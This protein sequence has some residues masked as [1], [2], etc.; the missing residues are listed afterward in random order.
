MVDSAFGSSTLQFGFAA[1]CRRQ[2][3]LEAQAIQSD[4][5]AHFRRA[6]KPNGRL[7]PC[8][9]WAAWDSHEARRKAPVGLFRPTIF[10]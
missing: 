8:Y 3:H 10:W 1:D 7:P 4:A 5:D 9:A 6:E 2:P